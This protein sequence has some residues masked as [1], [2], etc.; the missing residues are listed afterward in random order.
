MAGSDSDR[1]HSW[2]EKLRSGGTV[3]YL[4]P[5]NCLNGWAT[6]TG[7]NFMV[8]GP[9]Y[10]S[11]KIK[12]NGG[13]YLLEPLGFDWI[14]GPTK[15]GEILRNPNH[16]VRRAIDD[17]VASGNKPYVWA[18]N[19]QLPTKDNYSAIM[20]FVALEPIQD[21]SLM[22]MFLKGDDTF[23][24]SRLK[25]IANIVQGPW[26]VRAAVGEQAICILGRALS[27]K[28]T[29]GLNYIEVDVDI[30]SSIIA[31]A[32]LHLAFGY[33]TTLTTDLA[34]L[35]ESQ[36]EEELPEQ[37]LGAVRF[38]NLNPAS[39]GHYD[40]TDDVDAGSHPPLLPTRLWRSIGFG[41]T[42][43]PL[44]GSL[45]SSSTMSDHANGNHHGENDT[46]NDEIW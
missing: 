25:L 20:Y 36:T 31:N 21:G 43:L 5:E 6:P 32:I 13:K 44:Q 8:R 24:N 37:I 45:E 12:I 27:C 9:N 15:I 10:L 26:I 1:D 29:S 40:L 4:E 19:L 7:D 16:H 14:K 41:F 23:R 17:E 3:P 46:K 39:A 2:I 11:D 30:G 18:F 22:D 35:I 38:S 34:F 28:Y 42:S 33:V